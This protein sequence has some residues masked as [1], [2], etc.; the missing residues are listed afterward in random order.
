MAQ[1]YFLLRF[2]TNVV[3]REREYKLSR[4]A[5]VLLLLAKEAENANSH[6]SDEGATALAQAM[7][8]N[9]TL[10]VLSLY[11]NKISDKGVTAL[12]QAMK[13]NTTLRRL[14]LSDNQIGDEGATALAQTMKGNT[15]LQ[16]LYLGHNL[17]KE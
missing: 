15:T 3:T 10:Q 2:T 9:A 8:G 11:N 6:N 13:G 14:Y 12:A 5:W 7:K 16:E 17:M 4:L 1:Q